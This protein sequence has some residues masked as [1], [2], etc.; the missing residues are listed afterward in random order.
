[1]LLA[2]IPIAYLADVLTIGQLYAV[3]FL[4][5]ICTVFFDVAYQ[6]YLPSLVEREQIIDG[7]SK[8]EISRSSAQIS[9][10]GLAGGLVELFTAPYAVLVDAIS[11][12]VSGLFLLR[13]RKAE[14]P[15]P[16]A[17]RRREPKPSMRV[18]RQGGPPLRPRQPLPPRHA[19]CTATSN[20]FFSLAFAIFLVYAVR[21][22]GHLTRA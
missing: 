11:F 22:A 20:F 7:N 18:E 14:E 4:V 15:R 10:P 13:I 16:S 12:L 9:G 19:G 17:R 21:D 3:G 8:L 1:M 2:T 6:S 5:G